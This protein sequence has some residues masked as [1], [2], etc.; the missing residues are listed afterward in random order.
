MQGHTQAT[1]TVEATEIGCAQLR[2]KKKT[3]VRQKKSKA[4]SYIDGTNDFDEHGGTVSVEIRMKHSL[5]ASRNL[6][7]VVE[8]MNGDGMW[9]ISRKKDR[10]QREQV[11]VV[12]NKTTNFVKQLA[13]S[14]PARRKHIHRRIGRMKGTTSEVHEVNIYEEGRLF[15]D[16][17][18]N[19]EKLSV[20]SMTKKRHPTQ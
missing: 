5:A 14:R 6:I 17:L 16:F 15:I 18:K 8:V 11:R 10:I 4:T 1:T 9:P 7:E 20:D 3:W 12:P 13:D 2:G 19:R